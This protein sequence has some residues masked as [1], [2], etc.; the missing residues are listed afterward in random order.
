MKTVLVV[1]P[2]ADDEVLG[3][4][5]VIAK[6]SYEGDSV[7]VVV[8]TNASVGAPELFSVEDVLAIREEAIKSHDKLGVK[9]T[10]FLDFPAPNLT[11]AKHYQISLTLGD[12]LKKLNPQIVYLPHPSDLHTDHKVVYQTSLVALRPFAA[13]TVREIYCYETLSETE[14]ATYQGISHFKPNVYVDIT[15]Y[16]ERKL[17][18]MSCYASQLK[19]FPHPRSLKALKALSELRGSVINRNNAEAFELVRLIK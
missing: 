9:N 3:C 4:G 13:K 7:H 2:H 8:M 11:N 17:D 12:L 1:A 15:E 18:A 10:I 5:G 16:I 14:W 6:H 19:D